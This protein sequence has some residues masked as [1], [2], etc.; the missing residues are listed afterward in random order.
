MKSAS[1]DHRGTESQRK[2]QR[3]AQPLSEFGGEVKSGLTPD[4]EL[5]MDHLID[6]WQAYLK[7]PKQHPNDIQEFAA[8][9][10]DLQAR[11][12]IRI[13]RRDYPQYWFSE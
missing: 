3:C 6:A 2:A 8:R 9:L 10:H 11:I 12:A 1:I 4:E 13:V 5:V 7:L